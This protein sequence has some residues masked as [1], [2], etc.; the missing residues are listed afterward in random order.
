MPHLTV[1][2]PSGYSDFEDY[3]YTYRLCVVK[4]SRESVTLKGSSVSR[5]RKDFQDEECI[6]PLAPA[7]VKNKQVGVGWGW[8]TRVYCITN[9]RLLLVKRKSSL[10]VPWRHVGAEIIGPGFVNVDIRWMWITSTHLATWPQG[11]S[12]RNALVRNAEVRPMCSLLCSVRSRSTSSRV[13]NCGMC[14]YK[15]RCTDCTAARIVVGRFP[16]RAVLQIAET[17]CGADVEP[18]YRTGVAQRVGRGIAFLRCVIPV[19]FVQYKG[20]LL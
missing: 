5:V 1:I 3:V 6:L 12:P 19:V 18:R 10:C 2:D 17:S 8:K 7:V 4:S 9:T 20:I 14:I 11:K 15:G 16:A 13:I